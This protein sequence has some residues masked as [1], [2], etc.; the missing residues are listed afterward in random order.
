MHTP[1]DYSISRRNILSIFNTR[2]GRNMHV[3]GISVEP[4]KKPRCD[5]M[6]QSRPRSLQRIRALITI[7][8]FFMLCAGVATA[9]E[10]TITAP[11]SVQ[12][13]M[14]LVINGSSNLPPAISVDIVLSRAEYTTEELA[15]QTVTLQGTKEFSVIFDT[16]DL[17]KGQYKVEVP[18]ISG[19]TF[20]GD[21]TTIKIVQIVDRS[22]EVMVKSPRTQEMDGTLEVKGIIP[23]QKSAGVQIQVIGPKNEVVFG[24]E[25]IVTL[26]DG[27]F[28][29]DVKIDG[30][31]TYEVSFT[32]SRGFIGTYPFNVTAPFVPVTP[33]PTP[34]TAGVAITATAPST[35]DHPAYFVVTAPPGE[36]N[37]TTSAGIDW[38]IEYPD[39]RG[40]IQKINNKGQQDSEEVTIL[41]QGETIY[42][43]VY[44][45][46][47]SDR[48]DVT[49]FA[50]G[51][52]K[53]GVASEMPPAFVTTTSPT[54]KSPIP[55]GITLGALLIVGLR[56]LRQ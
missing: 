11:S 16:K 31:G 24:P 47:F 41:A 49:I 14:P 53:V 38:I 28:M 40:T 42:L 23:T 55:L 15:R 48:G 6:T 20:L 13:G 29:R 50:E 35:A 8:V 51:A 25:Y 27:S 44:P 26:S 3:P 54:Q 5:T 36:V 39:S 2:D 7:T 37:I 52:E 56:R 45:Y 1:E 30:P 4:D 10:L 17:P 33:T 21:S 32:D 34:D 18:G 43:K 19:Y 12:K 9:Y 22:D 46:R